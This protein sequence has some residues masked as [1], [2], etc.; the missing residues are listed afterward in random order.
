M[1]FDPITYKDLEEIR[2]LQPDGW[3]DITNS[4]DF[5]IRSEFCYPI[6]VVIEDKIIGIG[7]SIIFIDTAWIAHIIVD[8]E[9]RNK[10]VGSQ[11]VYKLLNDI[12]AKSI[13]TV[14]LIATELGEPVYKK[15]GFRNLSDY[16]YFKRAKPWIDK[17]ISDKICP[18]KADYYSDLVQLDK[19]ISGEERVSLIEKYI[20]KSYVFIDN[21]DLH[22]FYI[23][24]LG[25]G[26]I[27]ARTDN[28]GLELMKMKYSKIDKAVLPCENKIGIEFL[29]QHGFESDG[30]KGKRMILGKK[31]DWQ[32]AR[33]YS[34]IG[35]NFG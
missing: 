3:P 12:K 25:E 4:F 24:T 28:V 5:Y 14:L 18:Y 10:G 31:I 7:N 1:Q 32:P 26:P 9:Y 6:K 22:G 21:N 33:F 16:V 35:G 2:N 27:F 11:I 29:S 34:R 19:E 13:N 8:P 23:P 15:A 17:A 20:D 30:V